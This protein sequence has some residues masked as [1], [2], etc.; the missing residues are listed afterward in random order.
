MIGKTFEEFL[1]EAGHAVEVEVNN[2]TGEVMYHIN[3]ETISSNDISKSQYAGL[4]R[5]YTMLSED[6][7]KK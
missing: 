3:G 1:R 4:Q 7:F 6:K 5:R 2:R